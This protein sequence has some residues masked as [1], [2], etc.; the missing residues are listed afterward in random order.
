MEKRLPLAI[1]LCLAFLFVWTQF[2]GKKAP[3]TPPANPPEAGAPESGGAGE[4]G[5]SGTAPVARQRPTAPAAPIPESELIRETIQN[6]SVRLTITNI[7]AS[8]ESAELLDYSPHARAKREGPRPLRIL[9]PS[10]DQLFGLRLDE[11]F[12]EGVPLG[13]RKWTLSRTPDGLGVVGELAWE[14]GGE[15]GAKGKLT[16][17]IRLLGPRGHA[18]SLTIRA[19]LDKSGDSVRTFPCRFNVLVSGGV[20]QE[21]DAGVA[22]TVKSFGTASGGDLREVMLAE[23]MKRDAEGDDLALSVR[24]GEQLGVAF[25]LEGSPRF[26]ADVGSYL[27]AF[28]VARDI[29]DNAIAY[30]YRVSDLGQPKLNERPDEGD[31]TART[32]T[33]VRFEAEL[34]E[35]AEAKSFTSLYYLGPING[36]MIREDLGD[37]AAAE[38]A[39]LSLVHDQQLGFARPVGKTVLWALRGLHGITGNWGW[40]IV[41]LT[42]CVRLILFPINRKSQ[43]AMARQAEAM[44]RVK[45]KLEV[46]KKKHGDDARAYAAAQMELMRK[47]KV[48]L[49]PLGGCLP[50]FLQIPIFFGLFSALRASIELRQA[51]WLWVEDLSQPD[52][53]IRFAEPIKNYLGFLG[54][55]CSMPQPEKVTGLHI[56]PLLM[57]AAWVV[58]SMLAPKPAVS[59]PQMEQQ[60]KIMMFMPILFGLMMYGYAAGLSLYWLTSSLLGIVESQVIRRFWPVTKPIQQ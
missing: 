7:G 45:P 33:S 55:C 16:K 12:S 21:V 26:V 5:A 17:E 36:T 6:E 11:S 19:S 60:R 57:T 23:V 9:V 52:H 46:L 30:M 50:I 15:G 47:E 31:A 37:G 32:A 14:R 53:L 41:L 22:G 40:A 8:I 44:N 18:A 29:P 48:P 39:A 20:F 28:W 43:M 13:D 10:S 2:M 59:D 24:T 42:F 38:A 35:G 49:V 54:S 51:P 34:Q 56:L 27:G 4:S 1:L 3:P 58:S 25:G